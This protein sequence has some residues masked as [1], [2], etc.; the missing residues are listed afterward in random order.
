MAARSDAFAAEDLGER[1]RPIAWLA[2]QAQVLER[3]AAHRQRRGGRHAGALVAHQHRRIPL[4]PAN[5]EHGFLEARI[6]PT[7]VREVGAV[8]TVGEHDEV[9]G[10]LALPMADTLKQEIGG[11]VSSTLDRSGKWQAQTPQMFRIGDLQSALAKAGNEVTDEA[12]AIEA[13]GRTP[14]LVP[15][16]VENFKITYPGDFAFAERLLRTRES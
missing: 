2:R 3:H 12:S 1:L 16:N 5:D 8:L 6:E 4:L 15:G 14:K 7:E 11:R 13:T 10:L 9:G